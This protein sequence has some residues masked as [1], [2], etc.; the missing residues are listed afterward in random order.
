MKNN[1]ELIN[2]SSE[3][4]NTQY[5]GRRCAKEAG[6]EEWAVMTRVKSGGRIK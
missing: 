2:T 1:K 6:R 3:Q 5:S 4:V